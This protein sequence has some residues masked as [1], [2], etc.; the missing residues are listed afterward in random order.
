MFFLTAYS[1]EYLNRWSNS[2]YAYNV[3]DTYLL[4]LEI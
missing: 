1:Y 4:K 3:D 2:E